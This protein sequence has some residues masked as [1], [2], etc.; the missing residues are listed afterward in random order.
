MTKRVLLL[1]PESLTFDM[2][3][4][5]QQAAINSVFGTYVTPM[6]GTV[7]VDGLSV[8]DALTA[9]NFDPTLMPGLGLDWPIMGI[10]HEDGT[11][12]HPFNADAFLRHLPEGVPNVEPHMWAGW[13]TCINLIEGK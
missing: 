11:E 6:P 4:Q 5:E 8:C 2:L 12:L 9:D 13:P 10:W 3:T 1:V 7:D